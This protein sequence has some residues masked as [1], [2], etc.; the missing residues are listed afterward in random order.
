MINKIK[1]V[2]AENKSSQK[3]ILSYLKEI[4]WGLVYN[5]SIR[6]NPSLQN[7]PLNIGRWA[8]NYSFF[9]VLNRIL[10]DYKPIN[11]L[12]IGLGES[13]KL[14]STFIESEIK[15]TNHV[16]VEH[17]QEWIN[18]FNN[19]FK[20]STYSKIIFCPIKS[21]NIKGHNSIVYFDL[22]EKVSNKFDLYVIDGPHGSER[23]SRYDIVKLANQFTTNDE[24]IIIFDDTNRKGEMDTIQDLITLLKSRNIKIHIGNYSGN[25]S[26]TIIATEKYKL[27]ISF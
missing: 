1:K 17:D 22:N 11:I 15:K 2:I 9:Y 7:L 25:K 4:E 20:L 18:S 23:F 8:G 5:D 24:F 12:E 21:E 14:I 3:E 16:I 13:T 6:G 26:Q 19:K 27:S 10:S